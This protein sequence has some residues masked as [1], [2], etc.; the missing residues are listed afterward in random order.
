MLLIAWTSSN[1]ILLS[2]IISKT[3]S[4]CFSK[5]QAKIIMKD[6]KRVN[7]LDSI[8]DNQELQIVNFKEV[9][10]KDNNLLQL[11]DERLADVTKTLRNTEIKLKI[12]K[13]F[14]IYGVP[15]AFCG[16]FAVALIFLR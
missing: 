13:Q 2:Q 16:G 1:S 12:S 9:L 11:K 14:T 4:L 3:D 8:I 6:L 10:I 7:L 15:F 5:E